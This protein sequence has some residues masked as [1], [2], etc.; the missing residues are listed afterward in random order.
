MQTKQNYFPVGTPVVLIF[1]FDV[2][3]TCIVS[4]G[5]TGVVDDRGDGYMW[6]KLNNEHEGLD[7]NL[8]LVNESMDFDAGIREDEKM[9][10][11]DCGKHIYYDWDDET[12][13]HTVPGTQC[14]LH[15]YKE[16]TCQN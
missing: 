16:Q 6:I 12:Y 3:P 5:E 7:D 13:Y 11:D 4:A 8:I 14:F 15:G 1:P 10:C 9:T 2:F